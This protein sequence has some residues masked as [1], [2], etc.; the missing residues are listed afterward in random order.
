MKCT[1]MKGESG[2]EIEPGRLCLDHCVVSP[3]SLQVANCNFF[4]FSTHFC[5]E[6]YELVFYKKLTQ[7]HCDFVSSKS[8][9]CARSQSAKLLNCLFTQMR[10]WVDDRNM[11]H[12]YESCHNGLRINWF[13]SQCD[14]QAIACALVIY[15]SNLLNLSQQ[16]GLWVKSPNLDRPDP[17]LLRNGH[18][19]IRI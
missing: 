2:A 14:M 8:L 15:N 13:V 4:H 1:W 16:K 5:P 10:M 18:R 9:V 12:N 7:I 11:L 17:N 19:Q 3:H 6:H